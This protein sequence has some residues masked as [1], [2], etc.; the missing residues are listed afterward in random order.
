MNEKEQIRRDMKSAREDLAL[1][2]QEIRSEAGKKLD[3][4]DLVEIEKELGEIDVLLER[5]GSGL[6]WIAVFGKTSVGKSAIVN[7]L[8]EKDNIAEVGIQ[9]D[10]TTKVIPY[11]KPPWMLVDVPGILGEEVN[12]KLA[13]QEAKKAHGLIFVVIGEPLAPELKLFEMV[14]QACPETPKI[15][16]VNQWDTMMNRPKKDRETV[17]A[18]IEKKMSQFVQSPDRDI[19]YGNALLY[20]K[21]LKNG[22]GD[23]VRQ[24]LDQLVER[25]Y[26]EAGTQ[27]DV[28][29]VLDPAKRAENL[30]QN[31]RNKILEVR[32]LAARKVINGFGAATVVGG[33]V[34]FSQLIIAPGLL[35]TM[36]YVISKVMGSKMDR[37]NTA[38]LTKDLLKTCAQVLG[39]EF[40]GV[41]L[42]E[43][44][45]NSV[46]IAF[47]P[48]AAFIGLAADTAALSYLKYQRTV[49]LGEVT[50]EYIRND[51]SW[52]TGGPETTIKRAK[53]SAQKNYFR[54]HKQN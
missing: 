14:S 47:G 26:N 37:E 44:V 16:F 15:V 50:L 25:L 21:D 20:D 39:L 41:V 43:T 30:N 32:I 8:L 27:G 36:V 34:P 24:K 18:L 6:V 9:H 22:E 31:I 48:L 5:L 45:I 54:L 53:E 4:K 52:G 29:N 1:A 49:V 46:G 11:E 33:F 42:A 2:L 10:L 40:A 7:A 19:I 23:Y 28:I 17:K 13:I 12:E 51:F 35:A 38:K 3:S